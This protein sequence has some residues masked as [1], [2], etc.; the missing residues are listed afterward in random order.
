MRKPKFEIRF[1]GTLQCHVK[2]AARAKALKKCIAD[3][4]QAIDLEVSAA[5][6]GMYMF[7]RYPDQLP[8]GLMTFTWTGDHLTIVL[9]GCWPMGDCAFDAEA[10]FIAAAEAK[11]PVLASMRDADSE[12]LEFDGGTQV[13]VGSLCRVETVAKPSAA[14]RGPQR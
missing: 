8:K 2:P 3:G 5:G 10:D 13:T 4:E 12:S 6:G 11:A 14:R 1:D 9:K 7:S